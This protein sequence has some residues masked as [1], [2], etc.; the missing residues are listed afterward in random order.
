MGINNMSMDE[1]GLPLQKEEYE[2]KVEG[3][4]VELEKFH[5]NPDLEELV[6]E[7]RLRPLVERAAEINEIGCAYFD[8]D[9]AQLRDSIQEIIS[10]I[11]LDNPEFGDI[12]NESYYKQVSLD[13]EEMPGF[14]VLGYE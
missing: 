7:D 13:L 12:I 5:T 2:T 4:L 3:L 6:E 9:I 10:S 1:T 11:A 14:D 8:A